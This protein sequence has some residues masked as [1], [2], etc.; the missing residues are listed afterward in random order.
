MAKKDYF[1]KCGSCI[2]CDLSSAYT[3]LSSTSFMCTRNRHRVKADEKPCHRFEIAK[4][5]SNDTIA[6]YDK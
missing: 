2:H 3:F 5:R 4:G 6:M 1:G